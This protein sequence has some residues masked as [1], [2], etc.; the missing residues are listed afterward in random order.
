M[1]DGHKNDE[2]QMMA[3]ARWRQASGALF[4]LVAF[5][6]LLAVFVFAQG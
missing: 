6:L 5:A 3:E 4:M 1:D 2:Q